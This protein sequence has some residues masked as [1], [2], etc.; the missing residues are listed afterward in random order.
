VERIRKIHD[1]SL[2]IDGLQSGYEENRAYLFFKHTLA[3]QKFFKAALKYIN[4][5]TCPTDHVYEQFDYQIISK[6]N[7]RELA[8]ELR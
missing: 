4:D 2:G 1:A 8:R 3:S 7:Q 6:F 5:E